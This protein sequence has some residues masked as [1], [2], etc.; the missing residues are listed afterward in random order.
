MS[1]EIDREAAHAA[2]TRIHVTVDGSW[3][4]ATSEEDRNRCWV[5]VNL[6]ETE[7]PVRFFWT[8]KVPKPL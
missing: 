7:S 1:I 5:D 2:E 3:M 4:F 8:F 6:R